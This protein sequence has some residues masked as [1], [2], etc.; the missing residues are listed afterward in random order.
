MRLL[1]H[2]A[3]FRKLDR[4]SCTGE[5]LA[6]QLANDLN[7]LCSHV[8]HSFPAVPRGSVCQPSPVVATIA[9]ASRPERFSL[10]RDSLSFPRRLQIS[11]VLLENG[12]S[13]P[14]A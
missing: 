5:L 8:S 12:A 11:L 9:L 13:G 2:M 1:S 14:T 4:A 3:D 7:V 6:Q 10:G